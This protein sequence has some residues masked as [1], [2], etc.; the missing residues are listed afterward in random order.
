MEHL[1]AL[2]THKNPLFTTPAHYIENILASQAENRDFSLRDN[3]LAQKVNAK[4][5]YLKSN[6]LRNL[7]KVICNAWAYKSANC[8]DW[9]AWGKVHE[10][11]P[12]R[13]GLP[14]S[15]GCSTA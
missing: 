14:N 1:P 3:E 10:M 15:S 13:P 2:K 4:Q 8:L 6:G 11:M 5:I 12:M 7:A 9:R